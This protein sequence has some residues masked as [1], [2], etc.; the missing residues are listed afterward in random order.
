MPSILEHRDVDVTPSVSD[1]TWSVDL[2]DGRFR[3]RPW[4]WG[5]RRRLIDAC[6]GADGRLDADAFVHGLADLVT[7]PPP[8]PPARPVIAAIALRLAG[9]APGQRPMSLL[10]SEALLASAW[11]FGPLELDP[12]PAPRLDQQVARLPLIPPS[13]VAPSSAWTSIVIA[14]DT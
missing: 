3:I 8:T 13:G 9:V 1:G 5:E 4:T 6:A 14:D 7:Q 2:P 10:D 12:Q 11:G